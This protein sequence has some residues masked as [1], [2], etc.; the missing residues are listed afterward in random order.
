M[1][2]RHVYSTADLDSAQRV[3]QAAR[4]A[5][6]D[7][8]ALSLIARSDI[9]LQDVPDERK[10]AK[11]DFLPAAARGAATGGAAGLVAGLVAIAVP[12]I[13]LTLAGAGVMAL[14]GALVGSWSSALIGAT[15]P[16][17]VRR[18]FED[19]IQAGRVLV[20]LDAE[21]AA[22][23]NAEPAMVA[24]GA[25]PLPYEAASATT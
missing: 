15:V 25:T 24:A 20:I 3:L 10:D 11:T 23:Q 2:L 9:E 21:Q 14:A 19:E 1:K 4:G 5:G 22:L 13:G 8:D 12:P 17:P 16:D 18:Q 7:N 6:I